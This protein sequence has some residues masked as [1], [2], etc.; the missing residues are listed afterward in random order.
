M[1][2]LDHAR[3]L[4]R[5]AR[6]DLNALTAMA[7]EERFTDAIFGFHVQ[8]ALEKGLKAWLAALSMPY[9]KSHD[10]RLL[11][12]LLEDNGQEVDDWWEWVDFNVYAVQLRYDWS[13]SDE[14]VLSRSDIAQQVKAL[15]EHVAHHCE[16]APH[17]PDGKNY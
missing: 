13:R 8:Q 14:T 6:D 5:L 7:D 3:G 2:D 11:L 4:L 1:N 9:P 17:D 12:G 10:L 16:P 15:L